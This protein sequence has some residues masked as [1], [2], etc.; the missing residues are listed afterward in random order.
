[1]V[2]AAVGFAVGALSPRS[3]PGVGGMHATGPPESDHAMVLRHRS[4]CWKKSSHHLFLSEFSFMYV[5][6]EVPSVP[7]NPIKRVWS[8]MNLDG[9][10]ST[11]GL[12]E[13]VKISPRIFKDHGQ[14]SSKNILSSSG[15]GDQERTRRAFC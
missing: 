13:E 15:P 4:H 14:S 3:A 10:F 8:M 5:L 2:P 11:G 7:L 12:D 9:Y 6:T 1:M